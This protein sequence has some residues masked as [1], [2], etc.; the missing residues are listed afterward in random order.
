MVRDTFCLHEGPRISDYFAA[1]Y[2]HIE[3]TTCSRSEKTEL[4]APSFPALPHNFSL[5]TWK[6]SFSALFAI[7]SSF[8]FLVET[9]HNFLRLCLQVLHGHEKEPKI[10]QTSIFSV[11]K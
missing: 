1:G 5:I 9:L 3:I 8:F 11:A 2:T 6:F 10:M 4:L 7:F